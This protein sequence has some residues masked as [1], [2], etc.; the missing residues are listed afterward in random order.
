MP[1]RVKICGITEVDDLGMVCASGADAVGFNFHPASPRFV[2]PERLTSL[3][4]ALP[5]FVEAVGVWVSQPFV[6]ARASVAPWP[7]L[8]TVQMHG[9]IETISGAYIPAFA[10]REPNDRQRIDEYLSACRPLAVL[11][12]GHAPGLHGGTGKTA[13]WEWLEAWRP[14]VPLILAGG[15][16]PENVG[17]A[18]RRI[19]PFAV[20]VASG[21]EVCP[22]RKCRDRVHAFLAAVREADLSVSGGPDGARP[23]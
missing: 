6:E 12:D 1:T 23:G 21:V 20:D 14:A 4:A 7:R 18:I 13:P 3:M 22:G 2:T 11:I 5:P 17:E 10:L 8:V 19:R 16:N 9:S 15:L